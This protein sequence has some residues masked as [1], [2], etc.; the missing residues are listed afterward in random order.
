MKF[1]G[2]DIAKRTFVAAYPNKNGYET[3]SFS[4]DPQGIKK[5][6]K[7]L[8][9]DDSHCI[10]EA[11]GNYVM[12]LLYFLTEHNYRAS[13]IN[14]KQINN[15]AKVMMSVTKTDNA[16][17][18]LIAMYGEKMK[19]EIFKMPVKS[20]ILLKQKKVVIRQLQKQI[21]GFKNLYE[22]LTPLPYKD[23]N[24]INTIKKTIKFLEKKIEELKKDL[25][26]TAS[27]EYSKYLSLLT[28]IPGIGKTLAISLI[29]STGCFAQF[30]N[31]KQLSRYIGICPT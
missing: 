31:S 20:I 24:S 27:E 13:M 29:V 1:I 11:T 6:I 15:F 3:K 4:N 17:A 14:P 28:T 7:T 18:K 23:I 2:I 26:D 22:S 25:V 30:D 21:T 19:P 12:M 10:M 8:S 9:C 5:F 16:D